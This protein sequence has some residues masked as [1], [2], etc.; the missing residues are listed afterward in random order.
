M[1]RAVRLR[2]LAHDHE[3]HHTLDGPSREHLRALPAHEAIGCVQQWLLDPRNVRALSR[4]HEESGQPLAHGLDAQQRS[5][6]VA[7][8][9]TAQLT[10]GTYAVAELRPPPPLPPSPKGIAEKLL[11]EDQP[12]KEELGW[13][14]V[15][16]VDAWGKP[17]DGVEL[18]VAYEGTRKKVTTPGNGK[19]KV[20]DVPASFGSARITN[21][22]AVKDAIKGR[23]KD[24][25]QPDELP[26]DLPSPE[27]LEIDGKELVASLESL[28]PKTIVLRMLPDWMTISFL[29]PAAASVA[30]PKYVLESADG[31]YKKELTAKDDLVPGDKYLQLKFENLLPGTTYK[32]TRFDDD[33]I[34]QVLFDKAKY[35]DVVDQQRAMHEDIVEHGYG[36]FAFEDSG[37]KL[38]PD[39]AAGEGA[40]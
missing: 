14:E 38:F 16:V 15:T 12:I 3:L 30:F 39:W 23:W 29:M 5:V 32:L 1:R 25:T 37:D 8:W 40:A 17:V 9:L 35:E 2:H 28:T 21:Q 11:R 22:K 31:A 18:E 4:L 7:A 34:S 10:A 24:K 36:E 26:P 6:R 27:A 19:V 13:F 20:P 33:A